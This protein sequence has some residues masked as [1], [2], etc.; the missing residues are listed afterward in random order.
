MVTRFE[1][2]EVITKI[3][4]VSNGNKITGADNT[5]MACCLNF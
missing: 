5:T 2:P 1:A 4:V 3:S